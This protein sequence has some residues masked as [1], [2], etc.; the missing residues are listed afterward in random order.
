MAGITRNTHIVVGADDF[1]LRLDNEIREHTI[2]STVPGQSEIDAQGKEFVERLPH[3][4][5]SGISIPTIYYSDLS[6]SLATR[7][8]AFVF[9]I[10][11]GY[12]DEFGTV[13]GYFEGGDSVID[14]IPQTAPSTDAISNSFNAQP[15]GAW[16][17]GA[18]A[19][20]FTLRQGGLS[21]TIPGT[22]TNTERVFVVV[23]DKSNATS[24]KL[25]LTAGT[26]S[27][28]QDFTVPAIAEYD[29]T[30]F[31]GGSLSSATLAT[32]GLTGN[33]TVGG[34]VLIGNEY[35]RPA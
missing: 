20:P 4:V 15:A 2:S 22:F 10:W 1:C 30:G 8:Q 29:I 27:D 14:G 32:T 16:V 31:D 7:R 6:K 23:D 12:T 11:D 35:E 5:V 18:K 13:A 34:W 24:R 19:Y 26:K 21:F 28:D 17:R 33:V 3:S 25:T 9:A